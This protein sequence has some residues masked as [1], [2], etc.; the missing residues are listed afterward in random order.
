MAEKTG[1][2]GYIHPNKIEK[3]KLDSSDMET[4]EVLNKFSALVFT[5]SQASH[6][7]ELL[8]RGWGS[9]IA[10]SVRAEQVQE[11]LISLNVYKSMGPDDM[12]P[13][14]LKHLAHVVAKSLHRM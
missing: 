3:G 9:K 5:A 4:V 1:K 13:R 11:H 2:G 14:D 12:H 10:P 7:P 8:S 6:V